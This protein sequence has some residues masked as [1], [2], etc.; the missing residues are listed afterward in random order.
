MN[1]DA[2]D[3]IY[4][5]L[6]AA[7]NEAEGCIATEDAVAAVA[8]AIAVAAFHLGRD[9]R[10]PPAVRELTECLAVQ[11]RAHPVIHAAV[12]SM[13]GQEAGN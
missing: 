11:L 8:T 13:M 1:Y 2:I 5:V 3:A 12:R 6:R 4:D 9:T 10:F 7:A